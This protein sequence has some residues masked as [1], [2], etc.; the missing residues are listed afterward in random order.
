MKELTR[1]EV[2]AFREPTAVLVKN[3]REVSKMIFGKFL[4]PGQSVTV[5]RAGM[6]WMSIPDIE[7]LSITHAET[8]RMKTNIVNADTLKAE[9]E[10]RLFEGKKTM[11]QPADL[12][13]PVQKITEPSVPF[14]TNKPGATV[15]DEPKTPPPPAQDSI[16]T[17]TKLTKESA[18]EDQVGSSVTN[19]DEKVGD[20]EVVSTQKFKVPEDDGSVVDA[21][22]KKKRGPKKKGSK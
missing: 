22:I 10:K 18:A 19:Q 15:V 3:K 21:V 14:I 4:R 2:I 20:D 7:G 6:D 11:A 5:I 13:A 1:A 12:P 8:I 9:R 16:V 17:E